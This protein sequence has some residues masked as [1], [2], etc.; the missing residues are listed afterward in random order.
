MRLLVTGATGKVGNAVARRLV[1]RGD[2]VVALV[3]NAAK[4]RDLLPAGVELAG[5]DVTDPR[6]PAPGGRGRGRR[7]Q[8][9]G[10]VRAVVRRPGDLRAG[11]RRGSRQCDRRRARGRG[12]PRR[13]H[14]DLRRLPRGLAAAPCRRRPSR[15]I[16]RGRPTNAPSST[17]RSSCWPGRG[18]HRGRD[19]EPGLGLRAGALAGHGAGPGLSRRDPPAPAGRPA[20]RDDA[21][22][23]RRRRR[24]PARRVRAG[25]RQESATSS[26]TATRPMRELLAVAVDEAGRGWVPPAMPVPLARGWPRRGEALSRVIRRPPLLGS[27]QLDLPA[28]AGARRQ[29]R[30]RDPSS[31]WS[32]GPGRRA[33]GETVDAG[34]PRRGGSHAAAER[35]ARAPRTRGRPAASRDRRRRTAAPAGAPRRPRRPGTGPREAEPLAV[36]RHQV[37]ARHVGL[38]LDAALG[39]VGDHARRGR[40]PSGSRSA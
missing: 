38:R 5:G 27:G 33:S 3:R 15:T 37:D 8:L 16:R 13:P 23:L 1:D 31:G 39:E 19:R 6:I 12:G 25:Q 29:L 17:P 40:R 34:W 24:R 26:P 7:L 9:H 36:V 21:R 11:Q 10:A 20:R 14:L 18:R 32:S 4:A 28:L 2:E 35:L 22:P 30:G